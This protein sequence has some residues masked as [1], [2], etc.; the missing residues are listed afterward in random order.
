MEIPLQNQNRRCYHL[1]RSRGNASLLSK[2]LNG[3]N[4]L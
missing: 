2:P 4:I 1:V 3:L